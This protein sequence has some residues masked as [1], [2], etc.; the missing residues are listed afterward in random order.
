MPQHDIILNNASGAAFR[1]DLNDALAA[2]GSMMKGPNAPPAPIAGMLWLDDDTPSATVWTVKQY[3]GADWIE[4]GR[5]DIINNAFIPSEGVIAWADVASAATVDLGAQASRSLR[6]TGTTTI[7]SFGTAPSGLRRRLR[8]GTGLTITHN[9]TSLICPGAASLVLAAG[10]VLEVESLGSGNWV[11][12]D[13]QPA[14]GYVTAGL[15]TGSGLTIE[16]A[17]LLGRIGAGTGA[18]QRIGLGNT[19]AAVS[20]AI[21]RGT[22]QPA[23][24]GTAIDFTGIPSGVRRVTALLSGVSTNGISNLLLQLGAS[25]SV[26]VTGYAGSARAEGLGSSSL[27]TG[28]PL[29]IGVQAAQTYSGRI[30]CELIAGNTWIIAGLVGS[31]T[32]QTVS[33]CGYAKTLAAVLDRLRITTVNGTDTFD[34]GTINVLWEF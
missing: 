24:S 4:W 9:A 27:A 29:F 8:I 30:T 22:E 1:G 12:V 17:S 7:S 25:G 6:L 28:V 16:T 11:V 26:E 34:A 21:N 5:L 10:D 31:A 15:I 19:A 23:T 13:F 14:S 33:Y 20:L 32:G 3:D 2:L 18:I